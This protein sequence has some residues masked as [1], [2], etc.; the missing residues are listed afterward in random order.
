MSEL[1]YED[2]CDM[3]LDCKDALRKM[4]TGVD[5]F[6]EEEAI[7]DDAWEQQD[8]YPCKSGEE[9]RIAINAEAIAKA[10]RLFNRRQAAARELKLIEQPVKV[11]TIFLATRSPVVPVQSRVQA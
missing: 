4:A 8:L 11:E 6:L 5:N 1:A 3:L 10:T 9:V 7:L 2:T